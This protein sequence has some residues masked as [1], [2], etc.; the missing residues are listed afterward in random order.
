MKDNSN[1]LG[2]TFGTLEHID[3]LKSS[4]ESP[5]KRSGSSTRSKRVRPRAQAAPRAK[6]S[7]RV[8]DNNDAKPVQAAVTS[9]LADSDL[10]TC[11][12]KA[13]K[14]VKISMEHSYNAYMAHLECDAGRKCFLVTHEARGAACFAVSTA[15][16][17]RDRMSVHVSYVRTAGSSCALKH[18]AT[19]IAACVAASRPAPCAGC[20]HDVCA[21]A[22]HCHSM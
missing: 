11:P 1:H 18:Q 21:W 16:A 4:S 9:D 15:S 17:G 10:R 2:V 22:T 5:G 13:S 19:H 14:K 6:Q 3:V 7:H 12:T 20:T 8:A